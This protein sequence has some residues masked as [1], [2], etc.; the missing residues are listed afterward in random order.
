M[1]PKP[2]IPSPEGLHAA[3][4]ER[5]QE[6]VLH[7]QQC[8]DCYR[9]RHPPRYYCPTCSSGRYRWSPSPGVGH[10]FSW[11]VTHMP[12]DRGWATEIPYITGVIELNE[13]VRL[14]A[15]VEGLDVG[16]LALG[17]PLV[18]QVEPHDEFALI[19]LRRSAA[20]N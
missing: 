7:L 11:T 12:F 16:D 4:Y 8:S 14:V 17:L 6:G 19:T 15:S 20:N 2:R 1:A 18:A 5:L 13:E 3:F 10:L 9:F